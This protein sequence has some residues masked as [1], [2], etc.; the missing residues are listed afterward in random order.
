M[1]TRGEPPSGLP[2]PADSGGTKPASAASSFAASIVTS[3]PPLPC[4]EHHARYDAIDDIEFAAFIVTSL[5][6]LPCS[7]HCARHGALTTSK[8]E[9]IQRCESVSIDVFAST[10]NQSRGARM[11]MLQEVMLLVHPNLKEHGLCSRNHKT[12]ADWLQLPAILC[13]SAACDAHV[14]TAPSSWCCKAMD[15]YT[16]A[17]HLAS[18]AAGSQAAPLLFQYPTRVH[19]QWR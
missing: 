12:G 14:L 9:F 10:G 11:H 5:P 13:A 19:R 16:A 8:A 2:L 3:S 15:R 4:G 17:E 6:P 1:R 18:L 7:K